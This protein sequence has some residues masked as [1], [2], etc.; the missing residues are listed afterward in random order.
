MKEHMSKKK[1]IATE[2]EMNFDKSVL[3]LI[4]LETSLI[5][6]SVKDP[7]LFKLS[8]NMHA[9]TKKITTNLFTIL[10]NIKLC[11]YL[12][13][14][15]HEKQE[16]KKQKGNQLDKKDQDSEL[17]S[18]KEPNLMESLVI[19]SRDQYYKSFS[20][21]KTVEFPTILKTIKAKEMYELY[22]VVQ[23]KFEK[24]EHQ[25]YLD[26]KNTVQK[27]TAIKTSKKSIFRTTTEFSKIILK[28]QLSDT[29][30]LTKST[31]IAKSL[32]SN[33]KLEKQA[34][35]V[36][37]NPTTPKGG[38]ESYSKLLRQMT[39]Q[40]T[41]VLAKKILKI[42]DD[43]AS[44]EDTKE[45]CEKEAELENVLKSVMFNNQKAFRLNLDPEFYEYLVLTL[46]EFH[47]GKE[48]NKDE[49]NKTNLIEKIDEETKS[50]N[51][52]ELE[53][54]KKSGFMDVISKMQDIKKNKPVEDQ[55]NLTESVVI[56]SGQ[57]A[58]LKGNK[59]SPGLKKK[60]NLELEN[61]SGPISSIFS[62]TNRIKTDLAT[63][64]IKSEKFNQSK[65]DIVT[66]SSKQDDIVKDEQSPNV[67][68]IK[69]EKLQKNGN[70]KKNKK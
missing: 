36:K 11:E 57:V 55:D 34:T 59:K 66:A 31:H 8:E 37:N 19:F 32:V 45:I 64:I 39:G 68:Q 2:F 6:N 38:L 50:L 7:I 53:S 54:K 60:R 43:S 9:F 18:K 16:K 51:V 21:R 5:E 49:Y 65:K 24:K 25:A 56:E 46:I 27:I 48:K 69:T 28:N 26:Q 15:Y 58:N 62:A 17:D 47:N 61:I 13:Q 14:N 30:K 12:K 70:K 29:V 10:F 52:M 40:S 1:M 4:E 42:T 44:I 63:F 20:L 22:T 33:T 35:L 23:E 41:P 67:E 3:R